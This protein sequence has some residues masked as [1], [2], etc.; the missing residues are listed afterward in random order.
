MRT[1]RIA[2]GE[3]KINTELS[4]VAIAFCANL[5]IAFCRLYFVAEG[6]DPR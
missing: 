6:G 3:E 2:P 4:H 5:K 1:H